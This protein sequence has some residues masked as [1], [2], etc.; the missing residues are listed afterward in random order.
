MKAIKRLTV[1]VLAMTLFS[2]SSPEKNETKPIL[3]VIDV[4][5]GGKDSG[6]IF[7]GFTEKEIVKE[8][9]NKIITINKNS[10][11]NIVL[12]RTEDTFLSLSERAAKINSLNPDLVISLHING[13]K[14]DKDRSGFEVFT[15]EESKE[16]LKFAELLQSHFS[17][18]RVGQNITLKNANYFIL[19]N[20]K[21]PAV[22][23]EMAYLTNENDRKIILSDNGQEEMAKFILKSVQ[24]FI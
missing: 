9:A 6:F 16:S 2:F 18:F 5:H 24:N 19:K 7:E 20:V 3:V 4:A 1:F 23:L 13:S 8:I 14:D 22:L 12:N 11:I 21:A 15:L 10:N 17:S